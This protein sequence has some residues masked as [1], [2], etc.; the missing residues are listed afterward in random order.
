MSNKSGREGKDMADSTQGGTTTNALQLHLALTDQLKRRGLFATPQIEAA[1]RAVPRHLFL[2][3]VPLEEVYRDQAIATKSLD[4]RVV[5]SSSQPAIMAIMLEQLALCEGMRVLEIGA[6]TGYNAAL[7]AHI[8]GESGQVVTIDIDEDIVE[9]AREH[10]VVA[11][12]DRVQV[13]CADGAQGYPEAAPFDRIILTVNAGDIAPAWRE[14]LKL[15][16]RLVLPLSLNG[17]QASVAFEHADDHLTSISLRACGFLGLRGVCAEPEHQLSVSP[18]P[19][20][21]LLRGNMPPRADAD[22]VKQWVSE[23]YQDMGVLSITPRDI[24]SALSFWLALHEP[25]FYLLTVRGQL[26]DQQVITP[27]FGP[28]VKGAPTSTLALLG[29]HALSVLSI[30]GEAVDV[31][32]AGFDGPQLTFALH[33]RNFGPDLEQAHKL[34]ELMLAWDAAGR[35]DEQRLNVRAYPLDAPYSAEN[36]IVITKQ[37]TRFVYSW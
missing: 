32:L 21:F 35:P 3:D 9:R 36:S 5:S 2:P 25:H 30:Q 11:G 17:P 4:E 16:G 33:I 19:D 14:Q 20:L 29:E 34:K 24:F 22:R 23:G 10:L 31:Q 37:W 26:A 13:I 15:D 12:F 6:G 28:P 7:M 18:D 27:L 1:F 8:V